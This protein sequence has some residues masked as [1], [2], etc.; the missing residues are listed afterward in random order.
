MILLREVQILR[1]F[2]PFRQRVWHYLVM[3]YV[4]A[5]HESRS[6][7]HLQCIDLHVWWYVLNPNFK[8]IG[9]HITPLIGYAK[10]I[11]VFITGHVMNSWLFISGFTDNIGHW[12][13]LRTRIN[14]MLQITIPLTN[15]SVHS[16]TTLLKHLC[17]PK[18]ALL[19]GLIGKNMIITSLDSAY[20]VMSKLWT[21]V[22]ISAS[23]SHII[24]SLT[25]CTI[26][27]MLYALT[28]T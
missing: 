7:L 4:G 9:R 6:I 5:L 22:K 10:P 27:I 11:C 1:L 20:A 25:I 3:P 2:W 26:S 8:F 28:Y 21:Q 17:N 16:D 19:K 15:A 12:T 14:F 23:E 18:H 24:I 13:S